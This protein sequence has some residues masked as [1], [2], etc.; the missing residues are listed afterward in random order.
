[1]SDG[2]KRILFIAGF[3]VLIA[4]IG[5]GIYVV[6]FRGTAQLTQPQ[7]GQNTTSTG[8]ALPSSGAAGVRGGNG[9]NGTGVL[10]NAEV[11]PGT[12]T[13]N[14]QTNTSLIVESVAQQLSPTTDGSGARFYNAVDGKFYR[15]LPD[16]RVIS[17]SDAVFPNVDTVAWGNTSDQ[18][19]LAF[20]DG[21]KI[22]Y[23]FQTKAQTTLPSH[24]D[25]FNFSTDDKKIIAKSEAVSPE[26]RYLV[27]SDPNGKNPQAIQALGENGD[28]VHAAWT[29]NGQV[30]AYSE[31]G[32]ALGYD[33]QQIILLGKNNENFTGLV[34]EGRGFQPLWSPS[35]KNILYSVWTVDNNYKP[36]L[37]VSGG[38][39]DN[40][41]QNRVK[42]SVQTW[43]NK[44]VWADDQTIFCAVP[45]N[46]PRGA[47]LQPDLFATLEDR[48]IKID[49]KTGQKTDLGK[50][51]GNPSIKNL[52]ITK[53]ATELMYTDAST[54]KLFAF[55]I[56]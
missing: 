28:K 47:A 36:D 19:I 54:G 7:P 32:E 33:R 17:L 41:N 10:P 4:G 21:S 37:W 49:L 56:D 9:T 50:P 8:G 14:T 29:G 3:V 25:D 30:V 40:V 38:S 6:F 52:V 55:K 46:L 5:Y 27:I 45:E 31:T 11:V 48:I 2:M 35:G 26:S 23:D 15:A 51:D 43:A 20:P 13:G 12:E 53:D 34:V 42:L 39:P 1:M 16:G 18:A 44:C 22:H 24:W